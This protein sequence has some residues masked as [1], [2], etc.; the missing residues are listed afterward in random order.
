MVIRWRSAIYALALY[1]PFAGV[2][3]LAFPDVLVTRLAGDLLFV[4]PAYAAFLMW[5]ARARVRPFIPG[6]PALLMAA[7]AL[8]VITHMV[9]GQPDSLLVG[10]IGLKV[11]LFRLPLF[12]LGYHLI[13]SR[14]ELLHIANRMACVAVVPALVGIVQAVLVYSGRPDLAYAVY[15]SSAAAVTQDWAMLGISG[16]HGLVRIPSTFTF[17]L[18][19]W[20]FLLAMMPIG[21][22]LWEV[23]RRQMRTSQWLY[24]AWMGL[25]MLAALASGERAALVL[26]PLDLV[27]VVAFAGRLRV[28]AGLGVLWVAA[29]GVMALLLGIDV[30]GLLRYAANVTGHYLGPNGVQMEFGAATQLTLFGLGTGLSTGASRFALPGGN[31]SVATLGF[32]GFYSKTIVEIGLPGLLIVIVLFAW[33]VYTGYRSLLLVWD[34]IVLRAAAA[35]LLAYLAILIIYLSKAPA[36][37]YEP[38]S[39]YFWLYAGILIGL[40]RLAHL[41]TTEASIRNVG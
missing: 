22:T 9:P 21:Y 32:E 38:S 39:L 8:L 12:F 7:L 2:L 17:P 4:V 3:I 16:T 6:I 20:T 33:L 10:L 13:R 1:T 31:S 34:D 18:G 19:Y 24:L 27:F 40:P 36:L 29:L 26:A 35:G 28:L 30:S 37:D 11:W 41:R 14:E 5:L 15:G 25:V 23:S